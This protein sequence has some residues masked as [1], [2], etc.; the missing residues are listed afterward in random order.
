MLSKLISLSFDLSVCIDIPYD[1]CSIVFDE[2]K[3]HGL[4]NNTSFLFVL[5]SLFMILL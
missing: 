3:V 4:E 1:M 2:R 5:C